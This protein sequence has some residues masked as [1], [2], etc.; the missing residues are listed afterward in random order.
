[1]TPDRGAI[2]N[3]LNDRETGGSKNA[4]NSVFDCHLSPMWRQ[5]AI[6]NFADIYFDLLSWIV[7]NVFDCHLSGVTCIW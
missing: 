5:M 6:E 2:E 4:R 7:F 3:D 1:M